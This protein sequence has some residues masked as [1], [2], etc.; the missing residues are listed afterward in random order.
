MGAGDKGIEECRGVRVGMLNDLAAK[1]TVF[2]RNVA[3]DIAK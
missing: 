3:F 2:G 1:K